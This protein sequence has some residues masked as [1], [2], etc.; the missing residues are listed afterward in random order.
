MLHVDSLVS[1]FANQS[2]IPSSVNAKATKR[3]NKRVLYGVF[4]LAVLYFLGSIEIQS[5]HAWLHNST[6][7]TELHSAANESNGCHQNVYHNKKEKSC[8]HK[9][10]LVALKKCPLCQLTLQSLHLIVE[11]D[12]QKFPINKTRLDGDHDLRWTSDN[13]LNDSSRAPPTV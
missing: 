12:Q 7:E 3:K 10:H 2:R 9:S 13:P 4:F 11:K 6:N 8:E 1:T 5:F